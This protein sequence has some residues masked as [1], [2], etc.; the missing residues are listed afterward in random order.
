MP[1]RPRYN[2]QYRTAAQQRDTA[3]VVLKYSESKTFVKTE[4]LNSGVLYVNIWK[5]LFD[6]TFYD[7]Y[8]TIFDQ[9]KI[10]NIKVQIRPYTYTDTP[11]YV[12]TAA[13]D[14]NG[15]S[16][17]A[18]GMTEPKIASYSSAKSLMVTNTGMNTL[19]ISNKPITMQERQ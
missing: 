6:S 12:M 10:N 1:Y 18:S 3:T 17:P 5:A 14:R 4:T 11:A 13:F 15:I 16:D 2:N 9:V 7:K 8:A 19:Y